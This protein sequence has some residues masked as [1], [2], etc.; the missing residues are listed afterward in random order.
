MG[1]VELRNPG[2][3][4]LWDRPALHIIVHDPFG[5]H[6]NYAVVTNEPFK[7]GLSLFVCDDAQPADILVMHYLGGQAAYF[8]CQ[9]FVTRKVGES[10]IEE[11]LQIQKPSTL[12]TWRPRKG[13]QYD[14]YDFA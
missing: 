9:S 2:Y 8:P 1:S 14:G 4:I 12:V 13:V 6:L 5:I 7:A 10:V 3:R 11:F